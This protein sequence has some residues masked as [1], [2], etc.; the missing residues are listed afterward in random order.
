MSKF[1]GSKKQF[2]KQQESSIRSKSIIVS[3]C[4]SVVNLKFHLTCCKKLRAWC[5]SLLFFYFH[6]YLK[7]KT[8]LDAKVLTVLQNYIWLCYLWLAVIKWWVECLLTCL[9]SQAP[10]IKHSQNFPRDLGAMSTQDYPH[11]L[12]KHNQN[13]KESP[14][15]LLARAPRNFTRI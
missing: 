5:L 2:F 9:P 8:I 3:V 11:L 4:L 15:S 13:C 12:A 10:C 6:T 1:I 7:L 14:E